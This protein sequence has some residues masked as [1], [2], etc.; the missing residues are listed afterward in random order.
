M[1]STCQ[2][3]N[4]THYYKETVRCSQQPSALTQSQLEN[5]MAAVEMY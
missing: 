4:L 3:E 5:N 2:E 1:N